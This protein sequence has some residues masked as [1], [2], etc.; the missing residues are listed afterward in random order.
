[1]LLYLA[2]I[3]AWDFGL[4][5]NHLNKSATSLITS[6][7]FLKNDLPLFIIL[8]LVLGFTIS[9]FIIMLTDAAIMPPTIIPFTKP[10]C[11]AL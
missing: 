3:K 6:P 7:D 2:G 5:A 1:M 9:E 11:M 4:Y 8:R 10:L